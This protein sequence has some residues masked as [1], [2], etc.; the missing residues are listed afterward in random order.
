M[1]PQE[2][3]PETAD[4]SAPRFSGSTDQVVETLLIDGSIL[5]QGGHGC[6]PVPAQIKTTGP[7]TVLRSVT[8]TM[9]VESDYG[10][11][12]ERRGVALQLD[13]YDAATPVTAHV[14]RSAFIGLAASEQAGAIFAAQA[15]LHIERCSFVRCHALYGGAVRVVESHLFITHSLFEMNYA[16]IIAAD[17]DASGASSSAAQ[18]SGSGGAVWAEATTIASSEDTYF[19][20]DS[21]TFRNNAAISD[22]HIS[23]ST[24]KGG[25]DIMLQYIDP[26]RWVIRD[27]DIAPSFD[28]IFSVFL[29]AAGTLSCQQHPCQLG[30]GCAVSDSSLRCTQCDPSEASEDGISCEQ[31]PAGKE[32]SLDRTHCVDCQRG[33]YS[34]GHTALRCSQC[35][36]GQRAN[37]RRTGCETP[38]CAEGSYSTVHEECLCPANSY[39]ST[40][41]RVKC[42]VDEDDLAAS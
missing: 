4:T 36:D 40:L 10:R 32:A 25:W 39:N 7:M 11:I 42:F 21:C 15:T 26:L 22:A 31:C 38:N 35:P 16:E 6:P 33:L 41:G 20:L 17:G 34:D 8:F 30:Y 24:V 9:R 12:G 27:T 14:E 3:S 28:P 5:I 1:P 2:R 29:T 37:L 13:G 18:I 19:S 23:V